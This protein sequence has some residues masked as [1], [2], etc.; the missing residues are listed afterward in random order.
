VTFWN[1]IGRDEAGL[2]VEQLG[3]R[4]RATEGCFM[5]TDIADVE[6]V[7]ETAVAGKVISSCHWGNLLVRNS[8]VFFA[9]LLSPVACTIT[10]TTS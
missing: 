1:L 4:L 3:D 8:S 6:S 9:D 2:T 7:V 5:M 10:I